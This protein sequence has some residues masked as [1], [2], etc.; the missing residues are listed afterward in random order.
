MSRRPSVCLLTLSAIADDPRVRR[1]GDAFHAAG[2]TVHPVGL[3][4]AQSAPPTWL[5]AEASN[6][7][8]TAAPQRSW[9]GKAAYRGQRLLH[10]AL[11]HL[12]RGAALDLYWSRRPIQ[13]Q[14][15]RVEGI[16]A[17]LWVANDWPML[18][19]AARLAAERGGVYVYDTHEFAVAEYPENWLWRALELPIV[20]AVE[21]TTI[22]GAKVVST[23]SSGIAEGLREIYGLSRT[24]MVIR[25][26]PAYQE[27]SFRPTGE[28]IRVLYHGILAPT[29]GLE[30][31]I[32]SVAQWRPEFTMT[33]RGPGRQ[34]YITALE[35]RI[36]ER[37]LQD[38]VFIVPPVPMTALVTEAAGF[39][40]GLFALQ[41]HS[42]HN[43][44]VLPNKFFEYAMAGLALCVSDLDEMSSLLR[45]HDLGVSIAD[46]SAQ[47]V[48]RAVNSLDRDSIDRYKRNALKAACHLCWEAEAERMLAAYSDLMPAQ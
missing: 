32:D 7:P 33:I 44:Y 6:M 16:K 37:G 25:N 24:P 43:Q 31:V 22:H 14:M 38:R 17:D 1:Q 9:L 4:G 23:V 35:A 42:R 5:S 10:H 12:H 8:G 45:Q 47:A 21:R 40:V 41:G 28:T 13:D 19:I 39:D 3:P 20:K 36:R 29:R 46:F 11:A 30:L 34:E 15:K 48:T 18:P 26:S 27:V 2:W